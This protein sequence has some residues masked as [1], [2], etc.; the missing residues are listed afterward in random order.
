MLDADACT[1]LSAG[2]VAFDVVDH[3][4]LCELWFCSP[5]QPMLDVDF[6]LSS[7]LSLVRLLCH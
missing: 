5:F 7:C 2:I 1:L 3:M 4:H 6:K